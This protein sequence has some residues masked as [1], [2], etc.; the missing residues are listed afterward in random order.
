MNGVSIRSRVEE[1]HQEEQV[2]S[3]LIKQQAHV[4]CIKLFTSMITE[5]DII[6]N[7]TQGQRQKVKI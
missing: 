5:S 3:Y 7:V 2:S 1:Q 4:K 6:E